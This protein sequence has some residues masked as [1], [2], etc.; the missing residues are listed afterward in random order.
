MA[1][2]SPILRASSWMA[3]MPPEAMRPDLVGDLVVDVGGGDHRLGPAHAGPVLDA[4]KDSPLATA[5]LSMDIGF[6]SVVPHVLPVVR[7][8]LHRRPHHLPPL[9]AELLRRQP[10]PQAADHIPDPPLEQVPE[11]VLHELLRPRRCPPCGSSGPPPR[12]AP[13]RGTGPGCR[14]PRGSR[15]A[16]PPTTPARRPAGRPPG[17]RAPGCGP[18]TRRRVAEQALLGRDLDR[19]RSPGSSRPRR[20]CAAAGAARS[21]FSSRSTSSMMS[22]ALR[23]NGSME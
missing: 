21:A 3:P 6:H 14:P 11:P 7:Q 4:A 19:R 8:V 17:G 13:G 20:A 5:S 16:G 9:A 1:R 22:S 15:P 2:L 23:T 18:S 10:P 12:A